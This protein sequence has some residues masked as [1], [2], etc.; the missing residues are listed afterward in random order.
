ML[1]LIKKDLFTIKGNLKSILVI[2][3]VFVLLT[4][5][6]KSDL[7]F[8]L[9]LIVIMMF[10]STFSYDEYNNWNA[11]AITLPNGRKNIVKSKYLATLILV[12]ISAIVTTIIS[13]IVAAT[14][15]TLDLEKVLS[16]MM[17]SIF[18]VVLIEAIMYPLIFK[19]GI[20]KGRIG[21]F[22]GVFAITAIFGLLLKDV[23]VSSLSSFVK[24]LENYWMIII[25]LFMLV[26]LSVSYQIS[27][28]IYLKK[29]F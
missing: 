18:S 17:G 9:P 29:E 19:F 15:N 11:Y 13:I 3:L 23:N 28:R 22:V 4:L 21:L 2:F 7:S 16:V 14:N 5:Q 12:L 20:E 8:I 25:P 27:K 26:L 10:M 1:G 24:L 6:G